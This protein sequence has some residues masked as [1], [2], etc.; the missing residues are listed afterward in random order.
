MSIDTL[1]AHIPAVIAI[2]TLF[3]FQIAMLMAT[4]GVC[5]GETVKVRTY[6]R[7]TINSEAVASARYV[8]V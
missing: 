8:K 5:S 2:T 3:L 6:V 7:I 4:V 1:A